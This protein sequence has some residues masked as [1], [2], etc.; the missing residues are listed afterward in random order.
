MK[1]R[2]PK[3]N[4][5]EKLIN[6]VIPIYNREKKDITKGAILYYSPKSMS[7]GKTPNWDFSKLKEI[8]VSG[9]NKNSFRFYKYK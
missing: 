9:I 8:E 1:K 3:N 7:K 6:T 2:K 5:Y 4:K